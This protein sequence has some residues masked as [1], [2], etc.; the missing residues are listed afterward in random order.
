MFYP[1]KMSFLTLASPKDQLENIIDI[2]YDLK[3]LHIDEHIPTDGLP[4]GKP[5]DNAENVSEL[6]LDL[7]FIKS[8]I[9]VIPSRKKETDLK[10][11]ETIIKETKEHINALLEKENT[12]EQKI[13]DYQNRLKDLT[14]LRSVG[15]KNSSILSGIQSVAFLAGYISSPQKLKEA[16]GGE[17]ELFLLEKLEKQYP[18]IIFSR[19][20]KIEHIKLLI[21]PLATF[22]H[23]ENTETKDIHADISTLH[24]MIDSLEKEKQK[25]NDKL[26]EM[27]LSRS[28]ELASTESFLRSTIRKAEAPLKCAVGNHS[29]MVCGWLPHTAT[30]KVKER[31]GS[32]PHLYFTIEDDVED[33]PTKLSNPR[34][35]KSFEF[36]LNLY[37]LPRLKEIDPTFLIFL[38]FPIFFGA[39][40]GDIGYGIALYATFSVLRWKMPKYKGVFDIFLLS[41]I[42]TIV[43]GYIFGEFFGAEEIF[44]IALHPFIHRLHDLEELMVFSLIFGLTHVNVGF[45][46]GFINEYHHHGFKKALFAKGSWVLL[47]IGGILLLMDFFFHIPIIDRTIGFALVSLS[48]V[49]L[50]LGE[51]IIGL[52]E[53]PG[54]ISSILSYLRLAA[55]GLASASLALVV[56]SMA[57]GMF[58]Q[59]GIFWIIGLLVLIMGHALNIMIGLIDAYL[60]SLRLHYVEMFTK[61]YGGNGKPYNPFGR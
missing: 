14:F 2:L 10:K 37:S 8:H 12:I 39:M 28:E 48:V 6:L 40:L 32:L 24:Q 45:I 4:L 25:L 23:L 50:F 44:G 17:G 46:F 49:T 43:F 55:V 36:F 38:S 13:R 54:L 42:S 60:Q 9:R 16:V 15:I 61:F 52:I 59:G 30:V 7:A 19:K 5:L 26:I 11:S 33:G 34:A 18:F 51:G 29:F 21:G 1:E 27:G 3:L 31:L 56:N 57:G 47:E 35:V 53:I 58:S 41:S 20:E 22:H